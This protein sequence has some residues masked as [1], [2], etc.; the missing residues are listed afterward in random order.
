M[1]MIKLLYVFCKYG[2]KVM[3]S[4]RHLGLLKV[5]VE[6]KLRPACY[7]GGPKQETHSEYFLFVLLREPRFILIENNW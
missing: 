2:I 1:S 5:I 3:E 4:W 6:N 7:S